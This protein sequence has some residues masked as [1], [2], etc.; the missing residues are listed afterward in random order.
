MHLFDADQRGLEFGGRD[1]VT[2]QIVRVLDVGTYFVEASTQFRDGTGSYTLAASVDRIADGCTTVEIAVPYDSGESLSP[3]DCRD[4][5][6]LDDY[7]DLYSFQLDAE[8]EV[9]IDLESNAFNAFVR[10]LDDRRTEI[11]NDND[12][13]N[14]R[15][16]RIKR[17]LSAGTYQIVATDYSRGRGEGS[18]EL[19]VTVEWAENAYSGEVHG[20]CSQPR[21]DGPYWE[22]D[23]SNAKSAK[24]LMARVLFQITV[25]ED[26]ALCTNSDYNDFRAPQ[27]WPGAGGYDGGHSGWDVQT[28]NVAGSGPGQTANV[29]FYSLTDGKVVYV[30]SVEHPREETPDGAIGVYDEDEGVTVYYLHA[31]HVYVREGQQVSVD[32]RLG[33]QGNV[34]L[35]LQNNP[36]DQEHVHIEVHRG[37]P[38]RGVGTRH[39]FA[40]AINATANGT[41]TLL[42]GHEQLNYLCSASA[43][44]RLR[45]PGPVGACPELVAEDV[46]P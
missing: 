16:S 45:L 18:Y 38:P 40:G 46:R 21:E 32:Q 6:D 1:R 17:T 44:S 2:S 26:V 28:T 7:A 9:T 37:A 14:G 43:S 12:D 29:P 31:R 27:P 24:R 30:D 25:D 22:N 13:G 19:R 36:S 11:E 41:G 8:A 33:I 4:P 10:L 15:D 39:S 42:Q 23:D 20:P 3:D 35:G 5:Y 34:G